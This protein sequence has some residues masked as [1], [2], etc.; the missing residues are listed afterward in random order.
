MSVRRSVACLLA[1][2]AVAGPA[3]GCGGADDPA[4]E[5][6]APTAAG[7]AMDATVGMEGVS[8]APEAIAI[9]A[10]GTVTWDNTSDISHNVV[11]EDESSDTLEVGD[12]YG[13]TFDEPGSFAY[14]CTFHAG[15]EGTVTV[16]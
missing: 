4:S 5:P 14:Q 10:G 2:L 8:F 7:G 15:M 12:S 3:A 11:F 9:A 13:R 1:A 16:E 6:A